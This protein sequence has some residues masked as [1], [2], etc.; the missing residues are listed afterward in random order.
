MPLIDLVLIS[1]H[2]DYIEGLNSE[3]IKREYI[4]K[5]SIENV[6]LLINEGPANIKT[7]LKVANLN[8]D[9]F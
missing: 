1:N 6:P 7:L 4:K 8:K 2:K 3:D 5:F 9:P